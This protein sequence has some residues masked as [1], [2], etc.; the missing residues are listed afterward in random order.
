MCSEPFSLRIADELDAL[1]VTGDDKP[2]DAPI[3]TG[4]RD[5]DREPRVGVIDDKRTL[6]GEDDANGRPV[7]GLAS[8]PSTTAG[9]RPAPGSYSVFGEL[10]LLRAR[11]SEPLLY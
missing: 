8:A 6:H 5:V 9:A 7:P 10:P 2:P 1:S 11:F 3:V 4:N